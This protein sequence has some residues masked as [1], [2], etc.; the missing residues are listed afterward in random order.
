MMFGKFSCRSFLFSLVLVLLV[1]YGTSKLHWVTP[2]DPPLFHWHGQEIWRLSKDFTLWITFLRFDGYMVS[3]RHILEAS[4]RHRFSVSHSFCREEVVLM[5]TSC[6][7]L[8]LGYI[9]TTGTSMIFCRISVFSWNPCYL[10][11]IMNPVA[12]SL[13]KPPAVHPSWLS[14]NFSSAR[15]SSRGCSSV[16]VCVTTC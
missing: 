11:W 14:Y 10:T 12:G 7:P 1:L 3:L 13:P 15:I 4:K 5:P 9:F 8:V 16:L 2:L 6:F